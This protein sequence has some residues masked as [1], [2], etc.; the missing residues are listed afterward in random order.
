MHRLFGTSFFF[1]L[2]RDA[3]VNHLDSARKQEAMVY[4]AFRDQA[5]TAKLHSNSSDGA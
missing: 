3:T 1:K 5:P 4:H 2:S